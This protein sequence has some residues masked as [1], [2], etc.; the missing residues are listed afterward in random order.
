VGRDLSGRKNPRAQHTWLVLRCNDSD[1]PAR[2]AIYWGKV[3]I[4]LGL[5]SSQWKEKE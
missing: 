2:L 4:L 5:S 3:E 1:C